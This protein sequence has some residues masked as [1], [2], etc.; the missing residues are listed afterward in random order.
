MSGMK[1]GYKIKRRSAGYRLVYKV[2][3]EEIVVSVVVV[4]KR[5]KNQVYRTAAKRV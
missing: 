4:G 5:E 2:R 1:D 3:D